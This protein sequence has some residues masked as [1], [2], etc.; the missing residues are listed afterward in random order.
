[1]K[2]GTHKITKRKENNMTAEKDFKI[3]RGNWHNGE[4][5]YNVQITYN[6]LYSG[7]GKFVRTYNEA[8]EYITNEM[9]GE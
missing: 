7:H 3:I 4:Y 2:A 1:M 5:K 6:G 9:K 8:I